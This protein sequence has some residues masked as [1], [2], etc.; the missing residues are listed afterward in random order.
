MPNENCKF[1]NRIEFLELSTQH[2]LAELS[3]NGNFIDSIIKGV[4]LVRLL[5][6]NN[7]YVETYLH[8]EKNRIDSIV[9]FENTN[10]L[11]PYLKKIK[12]DIYPP[13]PSIIRN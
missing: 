10:K 2:Q 1:M 4:Y 8:I 13:P 3:S 9:A 7:Y 12:L 5:E 6:Y 11:T